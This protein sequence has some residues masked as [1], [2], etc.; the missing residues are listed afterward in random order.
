M[1][2]NQCAIETEKQFLGRIEAELVPVRA[3]LFG[4]IQHPDEKVR[5]AVWGLLDD[6]YDCA[7]A[8]PHRYREGHRGSSGCAR[9]GDLADCG[10]HR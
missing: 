1:N 9:C 7:V 4:G 8:L 3:V 10:P 2:E 6:L 5:D